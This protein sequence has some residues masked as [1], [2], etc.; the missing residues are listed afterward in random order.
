LVTVITKA[1]AWE[2]LGASGRDTFGATGSSAHAPSVASA[3]IVNAREVRPSRERTRNVVVSSYGLRLYFSEAQPVAE[4]S[5]CARP[6]A[7]DAS[8][9]LVVSFVTSTSAA[10]DDRL[11]L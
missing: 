7:C 9:R 1:L 10:V 8:C 4:S 2:A 11:P 3:A 6:E 5:H